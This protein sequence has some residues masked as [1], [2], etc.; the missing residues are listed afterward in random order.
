MTN[1]SLMQR[2]AELKA[3]KGAVILAHYYTSP[4][5]QATRWLCR[6]RHATLTLR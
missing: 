1:Q 3:Q 4:E 2:I 5:V 6:L